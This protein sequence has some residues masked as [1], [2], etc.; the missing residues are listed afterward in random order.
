MHTGWPKTTP[1]S[2]PGKRDIAVSCHEQ[3]QRRAMFKHALLSGYGHPLL[4]GSGCAACGDAMLQRLHIRW[5]PE[6]GLILMQ[7]CLIT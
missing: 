6:A 4:H 7:L 1:K 5:G 2:V 3:N